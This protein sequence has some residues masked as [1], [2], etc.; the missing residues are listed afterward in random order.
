M[1]GG[2]IW[3]WRHWQ[4]VP[5]LER[6][7]LRLVLIVFRLLRRHSFAV[8]NGDVCRPRRRRRVRLWLWGAAAP[9]PRALL[10]RLGYDC[11]PGPGCWDPLK[12]LLIHLF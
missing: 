1:S 2:L 6:N 4:V 3:L 9:A 7:R 11:S 5:L 12:I 8:L 10:T